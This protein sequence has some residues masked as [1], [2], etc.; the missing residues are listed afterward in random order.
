MV[1]YAHQ[2]HAIFC[3]V[4]SLV[5]NKEHMCRVWNRGDSMCDH[6][7][8]ETG[9]CSGVEQRLSHRGGA[10]EDDVRGVPLL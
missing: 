3:L 5:R 1:L 8:D 2:R 10:I 4:N 9:E 7:P 6:D